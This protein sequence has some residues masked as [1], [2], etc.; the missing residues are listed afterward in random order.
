MA[1]LNSYKNPT[2]ELIEEIDALL[3]SK[4]WDSA[5]AWKQ[6]AQ[7][8][9]K[10]LQRV[11]KFLTSQSQSDLKTNA[12]TERKRPVEEGHQTQMAQM[13]ARLVEPWQEEIENLHAHRQE[14]V[15]EIRELERQRQY[16][17][18]LAQQYTKQQQI[19]SE[20]SQA[21]LAPVQ[22]RII[23]Y[24]ESIANL[25]QEQGSL[26]VPTQ[27]SKKDEEV[28]RARR[29]EE[30]RQW[31]EEI[32]QQEDTYVVSGGQKN[33]SDRSED[34]ENLPSRIARFPLP[35]SCCPSSKRKPG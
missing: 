5:S 7:K 8:S 21:L 16:N 23:H 18:S 3:E 15:Q 1:A 28:F 25:Q 4:S 2:Q 35:A 14:L 33:S 29:V 17:Y 20:F 12:T 31:E 32:R 11:K 30:R 26:T 19:I 24:L 9:Q 34:R 22:E 27:V 6:N 10:L 13:L